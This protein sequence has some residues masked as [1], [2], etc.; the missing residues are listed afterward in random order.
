MRS[1]IFIILFIGQALGKL[2]LMV[3]NILLFEKWWRLILPYHMVHMIQYM[4]RGPCV[5]P[6]SCIFR[7]DEIVWKSASRRLLWCVYNVHKKTSFKVHRK[8]LSFFRFLGLSILSTYK[9]FRQETWRLFRRYLEKFEAMSI[10]ILNKSLI[11][12]TCNCS[13]KG[14]CTLIPFISSL[15]SGIQTFRNPTHRA[16]TRVF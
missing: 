10:C 11:E 8:V 7:I 6:K 12:N 14:T 5:S 4:L 9:R 15:F 3:G 1:I 13:N 2:R 16:R